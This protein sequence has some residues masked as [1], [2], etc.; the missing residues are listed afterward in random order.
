M[1]SVRSLSAPEFNEISGFKRWELPLPSCLQETDNVKG[2][3]DI[4]A[5]QQAAGILTK[6]VLAPGWKTDSFVLRAQWIVRQT[7][8][9]LLETK[10]SLG[11]E[12][13]ALYEKIEQVQ[14]LW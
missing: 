13:N 5:V 1:L 7:T 8:S 9:F 3:K 4:L 12:N 10:V 2:I 14:S 11:Y 6:A